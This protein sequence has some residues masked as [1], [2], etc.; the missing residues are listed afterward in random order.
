MSRDITLEQFHNELFKGKTKTEVAKILGISSSEYSKIKYGQISR[1]SEALSRAKDKIRWY[2]YNLLLPNP[3]EQTIL[4]LEKEI[5]DLKAKLQ[6]ANYKISELKN[7]I[8]W[9]NNINPELK[10][11]YNI[12]KEKFKNV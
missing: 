1:N 7:E 3:E 6:D 9:Y 4:K 5:R 11:I 8:L 2:G 12:L 10:K